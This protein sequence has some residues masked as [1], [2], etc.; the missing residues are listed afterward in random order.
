MELRLIFLVATGC[1]TGGVARFFL[2]HVGGQI[3]PG[4]A[5]GTIAA[6]IIGSFLAGM[7]LPGL[8][9]FSAET[10]ALL[11]TGFLGGLTTMSSF[12]LDMVVFYD[13]KR[14]AFAAIYWI[15][16]AMGCIAACMAGV[17]ITRFFGL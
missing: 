9:G 11:L 2:Q 3:M 10:R 4:F 16:G 13:S 15:T 14:F 12:A 7:I 6:N 8:T 17:R 5:A 1:A